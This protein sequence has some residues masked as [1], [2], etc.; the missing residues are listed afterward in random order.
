MVLLTAPVVS[1]AV[2]NL[3]CAAS[4]SLCGDAAEGVWCCGAGVQ[5]GASAR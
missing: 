2:N 5:G 1:E 3:Y 4:G